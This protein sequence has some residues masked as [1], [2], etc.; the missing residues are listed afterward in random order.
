M[1]V[2]PNDYKP[3]SFWSRKE[4]T[5]A[6]VIL[7]AIGVLGI[8]FSK[9]ILAFLIG[10]FSSALAFLALLGVVV[11]I[12]AITLNARYRT[13]FLYMFKSAMRL[14][15][16]TYTTVDPIGIMRNY[17]D[18]LKDEWQNMYDQMAN[19][20]GQIQALDRQIKSNEAE[21][22]A[23]M[24]KAQKAKTEHNDI[25]IQ[26]MARRAGRKRNSNLTLSS[27]L[28][29]MKI[30]YRVIGKYYETTGVLIADKEDEVD[31]LEREWKA[32][33]SANSAMNSAKKAISGGAGKE[34]FE[35]SM[36]FIAEDLSRKVGE[37]QTF[38]DTSRT[39]LDNLDLQNG[40]YEADA[41]EQLEAWEKRSG[42]M[43]FGNDTTMLDEVLEETQTKMKVDPLEELPKLTSPND[44]YN[45]LLNCPEK[46]INKVEVVA[47]NS[48]RDKEEG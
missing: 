18:D 41:L 35:N 6:M 27:L 21:R 31:N 42:T 19:L 46:I 12:L 16:R 43:I 45:E 33:K 7:G 34:M 38:V 15:A 3:K 17:I 32:V 26:L 10:L 11:L 4:G 5:P 1:S 8:I 9:P 2:M 28:E 48:D 14:I 22:V 37:I 24:Q 13:M 36:E 30:L 23:S 25:M 47:S 40:V 39:F 29:K 44:M 20:Q